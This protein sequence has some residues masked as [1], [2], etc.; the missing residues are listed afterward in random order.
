MALG[1]LT[2][3]AAPPGPQFMPG[4]R[5]QGS[6][7][8]DGLDRQAD[9]ATRQ[10]REANAISDRFTQGGLFLATSM[11]FGGIG[12]VFKVQRVRQA[13]L[14]IAVICCAAG[15]LRILTLP[16]LRPD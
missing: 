9:A 7:R 2:N 8:A 13:L 5:P 3:P 15:L 12:Q 4:Y 16:M 11:F 1:P 10:A 14:V 6:T